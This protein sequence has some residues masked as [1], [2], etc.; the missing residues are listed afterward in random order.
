M[1][2]NAM[3]VFQKSCKYLNIILGKPL[4]IS[5]LSECFAMLR[6]LWNALQSITTEYLEQDTCRS[7]K[8]LNKDFNSLE[9][10]Q[11]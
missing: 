3:L 6:D 4:K 8:K 2:I 9:S 11:T 5:W 10:W 7:C 1:L